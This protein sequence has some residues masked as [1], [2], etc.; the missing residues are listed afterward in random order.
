MIASENMNDPIPLVRAR[1]MK[2][3]VTI[4][5]ET[6]RTT[7]KLRSQELVRLKVATIVIPTSMENLISA[8]LSMRKTRG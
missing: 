1:D 2:L 6:V 7:Q 4:T 5:S 8:H 3:Q